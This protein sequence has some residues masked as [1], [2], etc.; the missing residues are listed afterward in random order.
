MIRHL[1]AGVFTHARFLRTF[2]HAGTGFMLDAMRRHA[3]GW[4]AKILLVLLVIS[5]AIWG[6]G[7][8]FRGFGNDTVATVGGE[9]IK[10]VDFETIY[11]REMQGIQRRTGQAISRDQAVAFGIPTQILSR[12]ANDT[13]LGL[14]ARDM[15]LGVSD[16]EL[17]RQIQTD[18]VFQGPA[19]TFERSYFAN[20][21]RE[22]GWTEDEYVVQKRAESLRRQIVDGVFGDIRTPQAYMELVNVFRAQERNASYIEILPPESSAQAEP[23]EDV[24]TTFF[25]ARKAAFR[26]PEYRKVTLVTATVDTIADPAAVTADDVKATYERQKARYTTPERRQVQQI[27]FPDKAAAEAAAARMA[28]GETFEQ[29]MASMNLTAESVDLGLVARE[30]LIDPAIAEAAFGLAENTPSPVVEGRFANVI[31]RVTKIEPGGGK[32]LQEVEPEIR[33]QLARDQA[34]DRL[35]LIRN[36]MEDARAGGASLAEAADR[37]KLVKSEIAAIDREGRDANGAAI[38]DLPEADKLLQAVF[39]SEIGTENEPIPFGGQGF[40]WYEVAGT[41]PAAD[42]TLAEVRDR[43]IAAWK[44][45]EA[46]K[47]VDAR[48]KSITDR[49]AAGISLADIATAEGLEVKTAEKV[50]RSSGGALPPALVQGLFG[51]PVGHVASAPTDL[52]GRLIA[53]VTEIT[54]PVFFA[55][56]PD[57]KTASE[58]LA[59]D[60]QDSLLQEYL[61]HLG[62]V[63]EVQVNQTVVNRV[64][65]APT[66]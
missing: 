42:R 13:A 50:T 59:N 41:T 20:L 33:L 15:G 5:F 16:T 56:A 51:G 31:L 54:D 1:F 38:P 17:V 48:A 63:L 62:T 24:L 4:V 52:G 23:A 39:E 46:A 66:N 35:Q 32:T 61:A 45:E 22:N 26:A 3:S 8:V 49:L 2:Q 25:E 37:L 11:Q 14:T 64:I 6:I 27:R 65:G 53:V 40:I 29:I 55:D 18:P 9:P 21:L 44:T 57:L 7:D 58:G 43:V 36:E 10:A 19:G 34:T 60:L 28:A 12:M 47:A 30:G